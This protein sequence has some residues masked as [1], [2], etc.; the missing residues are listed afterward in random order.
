MLL[1]KYQLLLY[2]EYGIKFIEQRKSGLLA[3]RGIEK[4]Q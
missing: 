2:A 1:M 4:W 3:L